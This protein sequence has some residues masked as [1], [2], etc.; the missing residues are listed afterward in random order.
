MSALHRAW[1]ADQATDYH[2]L[3][4]A[5]QARVRHL[6]RMFRVAAGRQFPGFEDRL[7]ELRIA[8]KRA[9]QWRRRIELMEEVK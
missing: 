5:D 1:L 6:M 3:L 8:S 9:R 7:T 4:A 2:A